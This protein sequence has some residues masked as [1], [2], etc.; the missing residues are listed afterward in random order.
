MRK[1]ASAFGAFCLE[2]A[3]FLLFVGGFSAVV[4]SIAAWSGPL[5]GLVGGA[6]LM[7]MAVFPYVSRKS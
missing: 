1:V 3:R 7:L 6:V 5:A 2:N 4:V